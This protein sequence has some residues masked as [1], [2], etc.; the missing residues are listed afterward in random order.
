M[1]TWGWFIVALVLVDVAVLAAWLLIR[2]KPHMAHK[3]PV[4]I[5]PLAPAATV[6]QVDS[7]QAVDWKCES[8]LWDD[9]IPKLRSLKSE[10]RTITAITL[11]RH[12]TGLPLREAKNA[13]DAL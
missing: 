1:P 8:A 11:L 3:F 10:G 9:L 7:K 5:P 12:R 13:V 6:A 4:R 2:R